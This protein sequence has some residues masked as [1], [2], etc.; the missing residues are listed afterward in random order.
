M[1][2]SFVEMVAGGFRNPYD[3]TFTSDGEMFTSDADMEWDI[4]APW[5]RPTRLLHVTAGGEYG[6]RS[7]WATW[8][9][10]YLDSLPATADTGPGSPTGMAYY[11]HTAFPARL[12]NY[13]VRWRLGAGQLMP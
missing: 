4:G 3:F 9:A 7:G 6:W 8:P 5:Y 1:N 11:D 2:G 10:Y 13:D 12:Q